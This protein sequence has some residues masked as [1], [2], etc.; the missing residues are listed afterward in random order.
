MR[1]LGEVLRIMPLGGFETEDRQMTITTQREAFEGRQHASPIDPGSDQPATPGSRRVAPVYT[2]QD[3]PGFDAKVEL[4]NPGDFPY[5]RGI[6]AGMY[7]TRLW[8]M[9][10]F[11]G[12]GT[13]RQTNERFRF[14][15]EKGQTGLSTAF[16]L[17]TLMGLDSDDPRSSGEVG[18]LGVAVDSIEDIRQ[19]YDGIDLERVSVS[20]T[21]NA[22]AIV[23]MA[24]YLADARER[25]LDWRELRGTIQND[26]L[27]EFHAQNEFV[28]PPEPSV[29]LVIDLIEFCA[30]EVP[31]WNPVSISGY[32][33]REAGSTAVQELAFTLAD[34]FHYVDQTL[35]RGLAVDD[36]APRLSFFFNAHNDLFEE[37]AKYRAARV[38]WA[39]AIQNRYG[40]KNPGSCKLRFH[41]QTAGCSLQAQQPE[42]NLI[43]VAYQALAAVLGGCQSLHTNS[44]D[45]TLALPSEHAVTLAVRTQQVLAYETGV[46]NTADPL[47]GGY[48]VESLTRRMQSEAR[49]YF[50]RIARSRGM[51]A[52][53][54]SGFFRRE[55]AEAS[56]AEQRE[57]EEKRKIVVGVNA[58]VE[59]EETPIELLNVAASVEDE[60]VAALRRLRERRSRDDV[61]R[62][63]DQLR[64]TAAENRNLMPPLLE[65]AN[66]RATVG[67]V[68]NALAD[69]L[70]RYD[71]AAKW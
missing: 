41:A 14:L 23:I 53:L 57:V 37:V 55:I 32:H 59:P 27:K 47:G 69:V 68:M 34:G 6:H 17:P 1:N 56:F 65:A 40:A 50:D 31:R 58:F 7:R 62:A 19:L 33:I 26:I 10:Q 61:R 4:G 51:I 45:E 18:R 29:R 70:G 71:G 46:T 44:M 64:Q 66:A 54:E 5:G 49:A 13:P 15:L 36:F 35:A 3:L 24:F 30:R 28:F 42:V 8:T 38:L 22:P 25:G 39:D 52:A 20:M 67:E 9:R 43:R 12:F 11:A 16:D 21:I 63:L 60:Q 48:F 2:Q